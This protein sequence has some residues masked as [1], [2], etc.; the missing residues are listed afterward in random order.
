MSTSSSSHPRARISSRVVG[1]NAT[2][3]RATRPCAFVR[4]GTSIGAPR[5]GRVAP[6]C[7][8]GLPGWQG[9]PEDE[10]MVDRTFADNTEA[11]LAWDT[12]LFEKFTRFR[13]VI[14]EGFGAH[15]RALLDRHPVQEGSRVI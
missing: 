11:T 4:S 1:R 2:G 14:L 8:Q 12:V 13:D 15:G 3:S 6:P 9:V 7:L 10:P 5:L